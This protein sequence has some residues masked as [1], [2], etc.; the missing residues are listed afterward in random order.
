MGPPVSFSDSPI[1]SMEWRV[2]TN[3]CPLTPADIQSCPLKTDGW[4]SLPC[5]GTD[6][7]RVINGQMVRLHPS[8]HRGDWSV[9]SLHKLSRHGPTVL[10]LNGDQKSD[11]PLSRQTPMEPAPC[12]SALTKSCNCLSYKMIL[13]N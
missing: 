13:A 1:S 8:T 10:L 11:P 3:M 2:S 12:V 7:S 4:G 5:G 6:G 9:S